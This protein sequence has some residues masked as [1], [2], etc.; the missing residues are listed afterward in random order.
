MTPDQLALLEEAVRRWLALCRR[1]GARRFLLDG[2]FV[3]VKPE[4]DD[5]DAVVL[6]TR[7]QGL[8]G[9]RVLVAGPGPA[10][11]Q[12]QRVEEGEDPAGPVL[13]P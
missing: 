10:R 5:I 12:A 2:S 1:I 6:L 9:R 3:T 11:S 8:V 4:P 13:A 7:A